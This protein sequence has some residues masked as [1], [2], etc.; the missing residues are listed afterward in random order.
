MALLG[1]AAA[2]AQNA[3]PQAIKM[4]PIP[5]DDGH[6]KT[7]TPFFGSYCADCHTGAKAKGNLRLDTLSRNFRDLAARET[8]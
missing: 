7:V 6:A 4:V 2:L 5:V 3:R 1:S 8:G